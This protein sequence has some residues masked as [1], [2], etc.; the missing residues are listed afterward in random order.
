VTPPSELSSAGGDRPPETPAWREIPAAA[1]A[2]ALLFLA[3]LVF[4]PAGLL[5]LPLASAAIVRLTHRRG[6][7]IA[8]VAASLAAGILFLAG[9]ATEPPGGALRIAVS[10][11][12]I[13][14]LPSAFAA[15]VRAGQNASFA[16][17]GLCLAGCAI[18]TG[19][20]EIFGGGPTGMATA[21]DRVFDQALSAP[22]ARSDL[23]VE[24][25]AR[26]RASASAIREVAKRYGIGLANVGWIFVAAIGFFMGAWAARPSPSAERAR[27]EGLR[28]PAAIAPFFAASGAIFALG[29]PSMSRT[30]GDLLWPL[31]ALY[32]VGGLSIIC[33][34]ARKWFRSRLLRV[35]LYA[36]VIYVPINVGVALL[37]LFDW[38]ADFRR[39]GEGAAKQA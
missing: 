11:G 14:A 29:P 37:G 9:L 23:D 35:G 18:L 15:W 4:P 39:R 28:V 7:S 3:F 31:A 17:L 26:L 16:Y 19:V 36:L 33:H 24:A 10:G 22:Q 6:L 2:S 12:V 13:A 34:F 5:T 38:Y 30:A 21:V 1:A 25:Q 32:F 27:F 20:I 8:L